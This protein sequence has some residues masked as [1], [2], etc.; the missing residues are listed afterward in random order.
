[1]QSLPVAG[2]SLGMEYIEIEQ[3]RACHLMSMMIF[4]R[5][6]T[7][8]AESENGKVVCSGVEASYDQLTIKDI[9]A[10]DLSMNPSRSK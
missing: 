2:V 5:W 10:V 9:D 3:S 6:E 8:I 1:M 4:K 7:T